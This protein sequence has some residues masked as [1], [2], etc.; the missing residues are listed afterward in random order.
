MPPDEPVRFPVL[1]ALARMGHKYRIE[2][3]LQEATRRLRSIFSDT[4][5]DWL[6]NK[7]RSNHLVVVP[8]HPFPYI[9]AVNLIRLIGETKMLPLAIYECCQDPL[10]ALKGAARADG[11]V[12]TLDLPTVELCISTHAKLIQRQSTLNAEIFRGPSERCRETDVCR[13]AMGE[14]HRE[15]CGSPHFFLRG[16]LLD[17]TI[18]LVLKKLERGKEVCSLCTVSL[19]ERE[20][21]A[22]RAVWEEL[23]MLLGVDSEVGGWGQDAA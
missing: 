7:G 21:A 4:Y 17:S 12:E 10:Q 14:A 13:M 23:P 1:A 19:R 20:R 8:H 9:E 16:R 3:V 5:E 18:S 11:T 2:W 6:K 22:E 15:V